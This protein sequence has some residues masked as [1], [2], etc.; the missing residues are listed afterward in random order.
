ME[1]TNLSQ[2]FSTF[3]GKN[4]VLGNGEVRILENKLKISKIQKR[5]LFR[6]EMRNGEWAILKVWTIKGQ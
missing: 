1:L 3:S 4:I 5:R 6:G 2:Q